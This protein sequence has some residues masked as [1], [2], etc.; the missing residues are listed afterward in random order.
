M[1]HRGL[2]QWHLGNNLGLGQWETAGRNRCRD[3]VLKQIFFLLQFDSDMFVDEIFDWL[4][5]SF[6]LRPDGFKDSSKSQC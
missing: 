2:E 6:L 3:F 4:I 1:N 5:H